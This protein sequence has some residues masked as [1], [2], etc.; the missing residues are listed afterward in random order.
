M[1]GSTFLRRTTLLVSRL[2]L[3]VIFVFI[4]FAVMISVTDIFAAAPSVKKSATS[5]AAAQYPA[6]IDVGAKKCIPCKMMAP[7]LYELTTE[8]RGRLRVEFIDVQ[9]DPETAK[10]LGVRGIPTQIFYDASGKE[11]HRH[12]G[13]ISKEDILATFKKL[14]IELDKKDPEK[15]GK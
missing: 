1:K 8:Y 3:I 14:G 15:K 4:T 10:K 6:L 5:P 2:S 13:Y 11:Q 7:I 12:L 9:T